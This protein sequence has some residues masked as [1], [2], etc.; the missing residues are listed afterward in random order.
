MYLV[1][2]EYMSLLHFYGQKYCFALE[3]FAMSF[4]SGNGQKQS[5]IV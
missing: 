3:Q 1:R 5:I 2:K 4:I